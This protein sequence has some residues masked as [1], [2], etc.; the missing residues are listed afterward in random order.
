MT[1]VRSSSPLFRESLWY[2]RIRV[3]PFG[4]GLRFVTLFTGAGADPARPRCRSTVP[5]GSIT[6]L[7]SERFGRGSQLTAVRAAVKS[8]KAHTF[9]LEKSIVL[10]PVVS[11]AL[12]KR[13]RGSDHFRGGKCKGFRNDRH[14]CSVSGHPSLNDAKDAL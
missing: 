5:C 8:A 3:L 13:G 14:P 1:G 7:S 12:R 10:V 11:L 4:F 6:A 9:I 2:S